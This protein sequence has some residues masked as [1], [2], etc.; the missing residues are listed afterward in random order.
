MIAS[1][2]INRHGVILIDT[3]KP[4]EIAVIRSATFVI[5]P[6]QVISDIF[7]QCRG[8]AAG[9]LP[10]FYEVEGIDP[11][12]EVAEKFHDFFTQYCSDTGL[13]RIRGFANPIYE[14]SCLLLIRY[15]YALIEARKNHS[16]SKDLYVAGLDGGYGSSYVMAEWEKSKTFMYHRPLWF[17]SYLR[18]YGVRLGYTVK[19]LSLRKVPTMLSKSVFW[20]TRA[21][22]QI[23]RRETVFLAKLCTFFLRLLAWRSDA[24]RTSAVRSGT[25]ETQFKYLFITR[26]AVQTRFFAAFFTQPKF[27]ARLWGFESFSFYLSNRKK[28]SQQNNSK[29]EYVWSLS[30]KAYLIRQIDNLRRRYAL[31]K[32]AI[33]YT[34]SFFI[35]ITDAIK[36]ALTIEADLN[37]YA[38]CLDRKIRS[39]PQKP[40][41][42]ITGEHKSQAAF[43]EME[44]ARR[45]NIAFAQ[46]L[47]C[48]HLP[49][50]LPHG[51]SGDVVFV[52][53]EFM[54]HAFA[55][56][57]QE[58][59][60]AYIGN[61]RMFLIP[62]VHTKKRGARNRV[63]FF[64]KPNEGAHVKKIIDVLLRGLQKGEELVI[65]LHPRD[66][67]DY[68]EREHRE[69][70]TVVNHGALYAED[71]LQQ[72]CLAVTFNSTVAV[73]L[74][75]MSI[76]FVVLRF[77]SADEYKLPYAVPGA[78]HI[79][80]SPDHL[81]NLIRDRGAL[82]RIC[83]Q[84]RAA[85]LPE[86]PNTM[87]ELVQRL[88]AE[89]RAREKLL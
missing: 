62:P 21:V 25:S 6:R 31:K 85:N 84:V 86:A 10:S 1:Q 73:T 60:F 81:N 68:L 2:D 38:V 13:K 24:S 7:P 18:L 63:V 44:V 87:V 46:Y 35:N 49:E 29:V 48:D 33:F 16:D 67:G 40:D 76:P 55:Q 37:A 15:Q 11:P 43:V 72:C 30:E 17:G 61:P 4:K 89:L 65:K 45:H 56:R 23:C 83:A 80:K 79:A 50:S 9:T 78:L 22:L 42:L 47:E 20:P 19:A 34:G 28:I 41:W 70:A 32:K 58:R 51:P 75:E 54:S 14:S 64:T 26:T 12:N 69:T 82:S 39:L 27:D 53:S 66:S 36:E 77:D 57:F 71:L 59:R 88:Q 3:P 52:N 8:R 74:V 5:G